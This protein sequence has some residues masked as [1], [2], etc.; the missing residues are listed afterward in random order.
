MSRRRQATAFRHWP[1]CRGMALLAGTGCGLRGW[2]SAGAA[3]G[4][5]GGLSLVRGGPTLDTLAGRLG[6]ASAAIGRGL[7]ARSCSAPS[8]EVLQ[9]NDASTNEAIVSCFRG[10]SRF[11]ALAE[12]ELAKVTQRDREDGEKLMDGIRLAVGKGLLPERVQV[13][14]VRRI[15]VQGRDVDARC[16]EIVELLGDAPKNGCI[17]VLQGLSGTGKGTTAARL[18]E[19]LPNVRTWSNGNLFRSLALLANAYVEQQ[20]KTLQDALQPEVLAS[21]ISMLDFDDFGG[22]FDVKIEGLGMRYMV[23]EV[24]LTVLKQVNNIPT[25]AAASQGEVINFVRTA[26]QKMTGAGANVIL[27]GRE[28]TLNY[29]RTPHRFELYLDNPA[30]VGERQAAQRVGAALSKRMGDC[31]SADEDEIAAALHETLEECLG[32]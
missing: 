7:A 13:E 27:E 30:L 11:T 26:L 21:L 15:Q 23:S 5:P 1:L 19:L 31:R 12:R 20:G 4:A 28:Q 2:A 16:Q 17:M 24:Q 6:G 18:K 9:R 8:L 14:P 22:G 29:I 25:V 10:N 3:R 32:A